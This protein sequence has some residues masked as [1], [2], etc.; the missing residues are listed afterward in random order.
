[1]AADCCSG[2]RECPRTAVDDSAPA[3]LLS[4][5]LVGSSAVGRVPRCGTCIALPA[6]ADREDFVRV[7]G[8]HGDPVK[9]RRRLDIAKRTGEDLGLDPYGYP[10][11]FTYVPNAED[12]RWIDRSLGGTPRVLLDPTAGGGS[13]P[14][15]AARLGIET[16]AN[17]LNPVGSLVLR[18]TIE[19]PAK[20]GAIL[21]TEIDRLGS[22]FLAKAKSRY[23]GGVP[24]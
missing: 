4:P 3:Y 18:A 10:R 22:A 21:L 7:L 15:E 5:C 24:E 2:R 23:E 13:I 12:R 6:E 19:Y 17:E 14:F 9:T 16:K 8:I 1:M 11:A 20:H